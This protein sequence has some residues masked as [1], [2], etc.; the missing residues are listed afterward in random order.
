MIFNPSG[1]GGAAEKLNVTVTGSASQ[2]SSPA[3]NTVWVKTST[4]ITSW[5]MQPTAPTSPTFGMV[6]IKTALTGGASLNALTKNA[7][8]IALVGCQ[9]YSGSAWEP[10]EASIYS[11]S[12]WVQFA[13]EQLILFA[14]G[15]GYAD[16]WATDYEAS[17]YTVNAGTIADDGLTVTAPFGPYS[18]LG[19]AA[20]IDVTNFA[21]VSAE[22]TYTAGTQGGGVI[23]MTMPTDKANIN[24][25]PNVA[26]T[27]TGTVTIDV[28]ALTG[29]YYIAFMGTGSRGAGYG[30]TAKITKVW[31]E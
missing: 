3:A 11:G 15:G 16:N 1:G 20:K 5:A 6:W 19:T 26:I 2:P 4:A 13:A 17:G 12:A 9:Q 8:D 28:S 27:A 18:V 21:A 30:A 25:S 22:V 29:E 10:K 23:Q 31:C 24:A 14:P 7:L